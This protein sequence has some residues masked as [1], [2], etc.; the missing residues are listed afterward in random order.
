M[1]A[2]FIVS[3]HPVVALLSLE[4]LL[5]RRPLSGLCARARAAPFMCASSMDFVNRVVVTFMA[6]CLIKHSVKFTFHT[7]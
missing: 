5:Q 1:F 6:R 7:R 2:Y 3:S 4:N